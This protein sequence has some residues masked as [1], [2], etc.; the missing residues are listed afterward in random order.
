MRSRSND[1]G[2]VALDQKLRKQLLEARESIGLQLTQLEGARLDPYA[3]GGV[4]GGMPDCRNVYAELQR[5]LHEIDTLLDA[6]ETENRSNEAN[7]AYEPMIRW[8]P[9]GTVG[10]PTGP[11]RAGVILAIAGIASFILWI[12]FALFMR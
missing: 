6:G 2:A 12:G 4:Q 11:T 3:Q 1:C 7:S 10:N 9:D 8:N 5:E